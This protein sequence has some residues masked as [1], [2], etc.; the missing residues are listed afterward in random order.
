M[1]TGLQ[2][3]EGKLVPRIE[4]MAADAL[5]K[6]ASSSVSDKKR[7]V[8]VETL[9]ERSIDTPILDVNTIGQSLEWYDDIVA[10]KLTG[11]LPEEKIAAKKMKRNLD[12]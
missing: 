2:S 3:F 12:A 11:N 8:M 1:T 5:S 9:R 10:Y 4:N 6:L 7:S